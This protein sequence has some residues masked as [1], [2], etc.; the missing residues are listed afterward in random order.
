MTDLQ[1]FRCSHWPCTCKD[2]QTIIHGDCREVLPLLE[3]V[4]LVLTDP[5]YGIG[6]KYESHKD[7]RDEY[8]DLMCDVVAKVQCLMR[9]GAL[10][11]F[12]QGMPWADAWHMWFP[13]GFRLFAGCKNFTQYRPTAVQYGWDPIVF[14]SNGKCERKSVAG[15]RDYHIGNTAKYVSQSSCG[16]PCPRP[17]DTV[18]YICRLASDEGSTV[19]DPFLGSGTTL[20]ACKDL[21]RRGI[22]IEIEERYCEIAANRLRQEVLFTEATA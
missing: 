16:H 14:W 10:A 15:D 17:M 4:D 6:F 8:K 21:G 13:Q 7:S 22:G 3:P 12:W 2:G 18:L 11:F 20:R 1:C 9:D 19:L 5:P